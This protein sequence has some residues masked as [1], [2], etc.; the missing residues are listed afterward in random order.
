MQT[1]QLVGDFVGGKI[2]CIRTDSETIRYGDRKGE[3]VEHLILELER[4]YIDKKSN[5]QKTAYIY[6][7]IPKDFQQKPHIN[8]LQ[9]FVNQSVLFPVFINN[10]GRR[11]LSGDGFPIDLVSL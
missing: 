4:Q 10:Y 8:R 2:L 11:Y 7:Y 9:T 5:V 1:E 6:V 3:Q